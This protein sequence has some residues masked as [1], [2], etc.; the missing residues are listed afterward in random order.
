MLHDHRVQSDSVVDMTP[1]AARYHPYYHAAAQRRIFPHHHHHQQQ[2]FDSNGNVGRGH[3]TVPRYDVIISPPP[4]PQQQ[5]QY[6][7]N[8]PHP[9]TG[10]CDVTSEQWLQAHP[11]GGSDWR[12][13][14]PPG[15]ATTFWGCATTPILTTPN[16][17]L[18]STTTTTAQHGG[19]T[20][21][22][23]PFISSDFSSTDSLASPHWRLNNDQRSSAEK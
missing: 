20:S 11:I 9:A 2:Q 10:A 6:V 19:S 14:V 3:V 17:R 21:A 8:P 23:P 12:A 7:Y 1:F 18:H 22:P 16:D 15:A 5:Q 4:P 13:C